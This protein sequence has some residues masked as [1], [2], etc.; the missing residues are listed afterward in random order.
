MGEQVTVPLPWLIPTEAPGHHGRC[1]GRGW[2]MQ[3]AW[4]QVHTTADGRVIC[5]VG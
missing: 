1:V 2:S 4:S 3:R 5:A